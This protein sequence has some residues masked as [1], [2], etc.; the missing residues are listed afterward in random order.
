VVLID[1]LSLA[2]E[3][4]LH[5]KGRRATE[6]VLAGHGRNYDGT[7]YFCA[8]GPYRQLKKLAE[9]G[10]FPKLEVRELKGQMAAASE[11]DA[12]GGMSP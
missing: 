11:E 4:E 7:F 10:G 3:V 1:E 5:F 12:A 8:P 9:S 6:A 2:I